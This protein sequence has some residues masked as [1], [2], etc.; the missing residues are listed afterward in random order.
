MT[1][2]N[3]DR[4]FGVEIEFNRSSQ[5]T[6]LQELTRR[7]DVALK[8]EDFKGC[9]YRRYTHDILKTWKV[10]TDSTVSGGECVSPI[11]SIA[12]EGFEQIEIVCKVIREAG[13]SVGTDTGLH[14]H[15][16][17]NDL[18][19]RQVGHIYGFYASFQ[20][21]INY[22]LAPSRRNN[23]NGTYNY[24]TNYSRIIEKGEANAQAWAKKNYRNA[25]KLAKDGSQELREKLGQQ[26]RNSA[27][28]LVAL[29][30]YGTIEFRQHQGTLNPTKIKTWVLVTQAMVER[31][32]QHPITWNDFGK[33]TE[34]TNAYQGRVWLRFIRALHVVNDIE[35]KTNDPAEVAV[36]TEAFKNLHQ[37]VKKFA[38][39]ERVLLSQL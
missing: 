8:A 20:S 13:F 24:T 5:A 19:R 7:I 38:K 11:L 12:N 16:D 35:R 17:A 29:A 14:V 3:K 28:N 30:K 25:D 6:T 33:T 31:F 2:V 32:V 9:I 22:A 36:Y 37:T 39:Q 27:V 10:V 18:T 21:V 26:A 15:H 34:R 1:I 23:A 4:T